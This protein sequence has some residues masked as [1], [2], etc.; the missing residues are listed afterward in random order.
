MFFKKKNLWK[1]LLC[2]VFFLIIGLIGENALSQELYPNRPISVVCPWGP[3]M[4]DTIAR[5]VCKAAERELGQPIIVE[6][7]PGAG[8]SL[9]V[10]Y[11]LKSKPDGY[12]LGL[13]MTSAYIV[14][15][16]L[17]NLAYNPLTST[18]DIATIFKYRFG[19]AVK[20]DAPW[21]SFEDLISYAKKN[22]GKFT[23]GAGGAIGSTQ[24]I[25]MERIAMKAGIN[26]TIIPF[27]TAPESVAAVLGD[28]VNAVV[29]GPLD[30]LPHLKAGKLKL[31]VALDDTRWPD[32][33]N[34]PTILEK[35]FDFYAVSYQAL[36]APVGV[37]ESIIKKIEQAFDKAKKDALFLKTLADFGVAPGDLSGKQYADF[38]RKDYNKMG[39]VI[40]ALG[41]QEK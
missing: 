7:K 32:Y 38:W 30:E 40:K 6:N 26:W 31:L 8:G 19:V 35:G 1:G 4:S 39:E 9:G 3:G 41:L 14:H 28:H 12:T 16:H 17:K 15:P 25:C 36:N 13:P 33:P 5:I 20:A 29:Q 34:V 27:K 24:H 18:I 2:T 10:N 21:N 23:Y 22:P 11:V 37:P